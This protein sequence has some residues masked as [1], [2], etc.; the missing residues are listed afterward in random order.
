MSAAIQP[1]PTAEV[2]PA[3]PPT[4]KYSRLGDY[5]VLLKMR[6]T[7]LVV[8]TAWTGYFLGAQRAHIPTFS[9]KL[10]CAMLGIGLVSSGAAAMNQVI[11]READGR[12]QRTR[13]RPIP[14]QRMGVVEA[15]AVGMACILGGAGYLAITTNPLTGILSVLT[16]SA[17]VGVYTPLKM[18]SPICTTIGALPGAM[19]P[20]LGWTAARGRVE[21]EALVLFAILFLW[22][23][24]HFHAIAWLYREDYRRAGIRMLPVVEEDGRSTVREVLAYSL[25]LVPVSLFPGYLHMVTR[26][27]I[28]GALIFS[29]AFL[30]FS[31]R[32]SRVLSGLPAGES[33]K[34]ARG[35]LRASVIYLPALFALMMINSRFTR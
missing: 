21:W 3:P 35:L 18:R 14:G 6:V 13:K 32:F 7:S 31:V 23:F 25:M 34:L 4:R 15:T 5:S 10:L 11:E 33:G 27:Y 8:M 26:T 16:A 29:L 19:P 22:Q 17:Y 30:V 12:M 24:P 20:L 28:V 9:W 2:Q 1:V